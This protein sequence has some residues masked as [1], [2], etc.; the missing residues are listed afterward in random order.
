MYR[1]I[2]V[3]TNTRLTIELPKELVGKPIEV[4][5]FAVEDNQPEALTLEANAAFEFWQQHSL[6]R[7]DF[8]FDRND[9]NER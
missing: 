3:S 4:L 2:L 9:A 7:N 8:E 6:D 1:E 5:A